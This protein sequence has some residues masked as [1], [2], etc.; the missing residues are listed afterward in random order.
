MSEAL[1]GWQNLSW[2][3]PDGP[4]LSFGSGTVPVG[5]HL[6]IRGA[7]GVG[8]SSFLALL[9]GIQAPTTGQVSLLGKA[10]ST[11]APAARDAWRARH[12]GLLPQQLHLVEGL[13]VEANLSLPYWAVGQPTDPAAVQAV[14]RR[15]GLNGLLHREADQMSGGQ[16]QRLALARALVRA[17]QV[18]VL[19]EPSSS[20]DDAATAAWLSL[21]HELVQERGLSLVVATHDARVVRTVQ[22]WQGMQLLSLAATDKGVTGAPA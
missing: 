12:L 8:K 6:L 2:S 4:H 11:L 13:T 7:S 3:R 14:A 15:L 16:R 17:P 10:W 18:L 1:I 20:L 19:D 21:V 5:G 9:C 22:E